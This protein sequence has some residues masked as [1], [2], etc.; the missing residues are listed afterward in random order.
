LLDSTHQTTPYRPFRS[1]LCEE[2]RL[3]P[4]GDLQH[5]FKAIV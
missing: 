4:S 5:R 1:G 2:S 3:K